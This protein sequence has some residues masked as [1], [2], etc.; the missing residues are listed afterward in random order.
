MVMSTGVDHDVQ[1]ADLWVRWR[2]V[3]RDSAVLLPHLPLCMHPYL[4][5]GG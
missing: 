1:I 3:G 4:L 5:D 2:G